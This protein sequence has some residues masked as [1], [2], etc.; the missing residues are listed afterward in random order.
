M[1]G[2]F[3]FLLLLGL[4]TKQPYDH[5]NN[6]YQEHEQGNTVHAVH[7]LQIDV[8]RLVRVSFTEV[9]ISQY[10]APHILLF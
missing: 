9:K 1:V 6:A 7:K 5:D 3:Y 8:S 4:M 2:P 10:L